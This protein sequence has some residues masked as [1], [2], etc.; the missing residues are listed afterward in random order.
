MQ[1]TLSFQRAWFQPLNP[2]LVPEM[3][4]VRL[5]QLVP[6]LVPGLFR[7]TSLEYVLVNQLVIWGLNL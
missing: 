1:L 7:S 5:V 3:L 6:R 2:S 4:A